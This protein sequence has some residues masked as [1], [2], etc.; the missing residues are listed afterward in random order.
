MECEAGKGGTLSDEMV[1]GGEEVGGLLKVS[2][3][4]GTE[5]IVE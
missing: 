2:G 3:L 1:T 5:V 4:N